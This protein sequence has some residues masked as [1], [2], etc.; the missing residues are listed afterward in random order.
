MGDYKHNI[1]ESPNGQPTLGFLCEHLVNEYSASSGPGQLWN[2][3][4]GA[5]RSTAD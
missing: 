3:T 5:L 2:N 1:S 4:P